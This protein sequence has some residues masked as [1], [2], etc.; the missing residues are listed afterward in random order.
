[1]TAKT[2]T[3]DQPLEARIDAKR[4][5]NWR[6]SDRWGIDT[7][8]RGTAMIYAASGAESFSLSG[9]YDVDYT[10]DSCPE[11]LRAVELSRGNT[12]KAKNAA[13]SFRLTDELVVIFGPSMS[14]ISAIRTL[15]SLICR[16]ENEGLSIGRIDEEADFVY[17]TAEKP[18]RFLR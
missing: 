16:I 6:R 3:V 12:G 2:G 1:M 14:A 10:F 11:Q 13:A 17:E 9:D 15:K 5:R 8:M 4:G 7:R 18:A